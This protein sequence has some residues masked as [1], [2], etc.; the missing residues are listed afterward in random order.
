MATAIKQ[1]LAGET[2]RMLEVLAAQ[3][4]SFTA[5]MP[6]SLSVRTDGMMSV[7]SV[8]SRLRW[9]KASSR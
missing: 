8:C 4:A 1:D 9:P 3:K 6:E 7:I 5:A 2:A